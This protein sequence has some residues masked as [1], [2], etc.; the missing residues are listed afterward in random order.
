M[1]VEVV[2]TFA[3]DEADDRAMD[4]GKHGKD[5]GRDPYGGDAFG[6]VEFGAGSNSMG[7]GRREMWSIEQIFEI[8][9]EGCEKQFA[10]KVPA[11]PRREYRSVESAI[12]DLNR[13]SAPPDALDRGV[14]VVFDAGRRC[15]YAL[16]LRHKEAEAASLT[17]PVGGGGGRFGGDPSFGGGQYDKY[18]GG[19]MPGGGNYDKFGGPDN[20]PGGG[21]YERYGP[22]G[23]GGQ[24]DR[25]GDGGQYDRYGGGGGQHGQFGDGGGPRYGGF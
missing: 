14:C 19:N 5:Y 4:K 6:G 2:G 17:N 3:I 20:M 16:Y 24:Y 18:G 23:G 8:G 15:Y 1:D 10:G 13:G 9:P 22:G 11:L 25:Y 7:G 21:N 12:D